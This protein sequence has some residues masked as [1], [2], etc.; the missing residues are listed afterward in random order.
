[1]NLRTVQ[2]VSGDAIRERREALKLT[3]MDVAMGLRALSPRLFGSVAPGYISGWE[4]GTVPDG[5]AVPAL[6]KVLKCR[7][8]RLYREAPAE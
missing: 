4:R 3:Q 6:A 1:M 7:V 8:G 2:E 5:N